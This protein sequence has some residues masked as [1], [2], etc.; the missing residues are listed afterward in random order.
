MPR[1]IIQSMN[2]GR[3]LAPVEDSIEWVKSLRDADSGV[4]VDPEAIQQ[5]LDDY[6]SF[7]DQAIVI[8]LE[9]LGTVRGY[10]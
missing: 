10:K 7:D 6:C 4:I 2:T 9:R 8:D 1:F 5:L 3:F